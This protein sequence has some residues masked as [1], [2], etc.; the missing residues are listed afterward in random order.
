MSNEERR[1]KLIEA[2]EKPVSNDPSIEVFDPWHDIIEGVLGSYSSSMD[3][4]FINALKA[5]RD[6][7]TFKFIFNNDAHEMA[8][9]ILAGQGYTDYGTSPRGGWPDSWCADLWDDMIAKWEE[10]YKATWETYDD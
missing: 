3:L 6:R 1:K 5:I 9:Y 7:T 4:I 8:L 10:Y 2:L